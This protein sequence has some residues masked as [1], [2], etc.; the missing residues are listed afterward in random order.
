M[1]LLLKTDYSH[2][3]WEI[4]QYLNKLNGNSLIKAQG[5]FQMFFNPKVSSQVFLLGCQ[6][7]R[8]SGEAGKGEGVLQQEWEVIRICLQKNDQLNK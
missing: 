3:K 6:S 8:Q 7:S 4:T 2:L 1:N 5:S